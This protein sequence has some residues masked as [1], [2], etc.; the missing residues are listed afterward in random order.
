MDGSAWPSTVDFA[1]P[2]G[3]L[4]Q[5]RPSARMTLPLSENLYWAV[6]VAQPFSDITTFG[7]SDNVQNVPDFATHVR[8]Q[9][10][11]GHVQVSTVLR[12]IAYRPAGG[13][14]T[15]RTGWGAS[16]S[17]V[18]HPW[19]ILHGTNPV[20][21]PHPSGLDRSRILLQH[22][23]GWGIGRYIQ[24]TAGLGLDGQVDPA[25][26]AFDTLFALGWSASYEHWFNEHWLTNMTYSADYASSF[27]GQ[28]GSTYQGAKYLAVSL[29]WIPIVNMSIGIEYV[30]G[31]REKL[32][33]QRARANRLNA[34]FQYNF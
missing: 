18:F 17:T 1:G 11:R 28:P 24:D 34:L 14:V 26:G 2:R 32:D 8:Y 20:Q 22:S 7:Q 15:R 6:G 4:N 23:F 5:R 31:E 19:A 29:W 30:W 16:A 12:S 3:L 21:N 13:E 9:G 25:T 10:D 27:G 33:T